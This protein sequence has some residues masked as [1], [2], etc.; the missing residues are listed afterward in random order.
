MSVMKKIILSLAI[1][2]L[3]SVLSLKAQ[4]VGINETGSTPDATAIL[5]ISATDKGVLI[6]RTDTATVN[7]SG[8]STGLLVY[9]TSDN[10]FYYHNGTKWIPFITSETLITESDTL[11]LIMDEDRD[12]YVH[13]EESS[14]EDIIHFY[15]AGTECFRMDDGR[16]DVFNTGQSVFI[17]KDAGL[18]DDLSTNQNVF[19]GNST[20]TNN[21][22]GNRNVA[23][24]YQSFQNN[25]TGGLNV[26]V[27]YQALRNGTASNNTAI[28]A[29]ASTETTSG[30]QNASFGS[31]ALRFTTT[32]SQ[33]SAFG[34]AA[35]RSNTTGTTNVAIGTS[36]GYSSVGSR[37][38]FVGFEAGYNNVG[39][40]GV[41]LGY[42]AGRNETTNAK[43]YIENS[44]SSTPLIWG[45]FTA[46]SV[47]IYGVLGIQDN[48]VF[49]TSDGTAGQVMT[50][51]G[52]GNL[53][54]STDSTGTDDQF[55]DVFQLSGN[56][57][58]LSLD[59]DGI[60]TQTIDLSIYENDT[61]PLIADAD[62]DT[63][64]HVEESSDEDIIRFYTGNSANSSTE[65][66]RMDSGRFEI[67]NTG[68]SVFI[69]EGAGANDDF[70]SN[71][72]TFLGSYAGNANTSG[73]QNLAVGR[74]ALLS[75]QTA[76][77]NV[78]LGNDALRSNSSG[79]TNTS[80][81]TSSLYSTTTG[82]GNVALGYESGFSATGND[83]VFLG[84]QSG[85][86][87]TGDDKLYIENTT[88]STP[89]IWGD[90]VNDSVKIYGVL[91]IS[92][93]YVFPTADGAAGQIMTTDGD[94][95]LT[96]STDSPGTDD[97]FADVFQL[98][99]NS[100]E[101]SLDG[102]GIA[103]Q[104]IDLS[105]YEN[106]TLPLI[107]DA[108]RDTYVHVEES[109]DEDIIRFYTGN[110]ANS[111]TEFFRMD[112]GR[113]E[114]LNTGNSV[115]IGEGA[116]ANDDFSS[117][118][119]TFLGS[120][121][122]NANTSGQQNV[123]V[124]R[125]A[126]LSN[127]T[128]NYNVA[129]GN[130]ALRS[131]ST[132]NNN[133]SV[134]IAALYTT[135]SGSGNVALGYLAGYDNTTGNNVTAIGEN[136]LSNNTT[137]N[138]NTG[139]GAYALG[140][141]TNGF[142]NTSLGRGSM[143]SNTT[144]DR[145][146]ALGYESG[147]SATGNDNVFL[148]NQ[149][150][151]NETGDDKLYIE[152]TTSSTP[153]IWGDFANDSVKI[154]GVLGVQDSYV[155][156]TADGTS[157]QVLTTDGSG[158]VSWSAAGGTSLEDAD[159]D[160][161]IQVEESAD[162][163]IIRFDLAGTEY[164]AMENGRFE[165]LNNAN[166]VLIGEDAGALVGTGVNNTYVGTRAMLL[167]GNNSYN[168]ALGCQAGEIAAGSYNTIL[169][170]QSGQN[171]LGSNNVL[172]GYQSGQNLSGSDQL[173]IENSN[174]D[175][176]LIWGDFANDTIT[177][178]GSFEVEGTI[179]TKGNWIS[180][181]GDNEGLFI[182]AA[183]EVGIGINS[184]AHDLDIQTAS[185]NATIA[186]RPVAGS[187]ARLFFYD[188][189]A[190]TSIWNVGSSS[191][192]NNFS[193]YNGT[194][195]VVQF[196]QAAASNSIYVNATGVGIGTNV[197]GYMLQVGASG[198]GTEARANA[199]NTFSDRR[200]KTN[201]EVIPNALSKLDQIN[202]YYYNWKN[203]PDTSLQVGVIA[204]EIEATLPQIVSTDADGYKSVDYSK[205]SALLIQAVK[206]QQ[207]LIS[208]QEAQ[209]KNLKSKVKNKDFEVE[210]LKKE[211]VRNAAQIE[212]IQQLIGMLANKGN[213]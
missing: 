159:S 128:A 156:P 202:G 190:S 13:V 17:G 149:S 150:G 6:P 55:A 181:D 75:N 114:I 146:L 124:G 9:Q 18:N 211:V 119:N 148:G 189:D 52:D 26:S 142:R 19:I 138:Y 104:T 81:G 200:W 21:T 22:T 42:Q 137:G 122:G 118:L 95:N 69:G 82:Y 155:F 163:D 5:D 185:G 131:N 39:N 53:T 106:D 14:D 88:S 130:N 201:F 83:N 209:I 27:G 193:F 167:N 2:L 180:N 153:L 98:S 107:A 108:D 50:T 84:N 157:G 143:Y 46:D 30:I 32:G 141:T 120:Y 74:N 197:P 80:V 213:N 101:L 35:L 139:I 59:G 178:N 4:N 133:T 41:Y 194:S 177:I 1:T 121:A 64:V 16:L 15:V 93:N 90:F 162:E 34:R 110:S 173:F 28:G 40:E 204:Q 91:G 86:N 71:L 72:N 165:I 168:V 31:S 70:S 132:G 111:S 45:D 103:T 205:L 175:A 186:L 44:A 51:D 123:A 109:S 38:L 99:G 54:W 183:G 48:Y 136:A 134:G 24:G 117:N 97:Q 196:E 170:Y 182:D 172:L 3:L 164:F 77:Y 188:D 96:W 49:P 65:F 125:N 23:I 208:N 89:L 37:N 176:P 187:N 60:A 78:A 68:N 43:L 58:E 169:G 140:S 73:Q 147:F 100:L 158:N 10:T 79:S 57:L 184:P 47:K 145:N 199:W 61:L 203:K 63:Y 144:G 12:T 56:S 33:N 127:Q 112:S 29:F 166:N 94:G 67:L 11:S 198:D 8:V 116:G 161:K 192:S 76:D 92:N 36:A 66:F 154:Y 126:L 20:A 113:F 191:A 87:E 195:S 212:Q 102:D 160:T 210:N 7:T 62:R 171:N 179:L 85:Y 206:E 105:I 152:N 151:Y 129:L 25:T 135:T 115:F 207:I 174:S